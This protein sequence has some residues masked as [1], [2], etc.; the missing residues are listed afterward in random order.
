MAGEI[1][2]RIYHTRLLPTGLLLVGVGIGVS[3]V[4]ESFKSI[5]VKG[6][7]YYKKL[8]VEPSR[9]KLVAAWRTANNSMLLRRFVPNLQSRLSLDSEVKSSIK[10][11]KTRTKAPVEHERKDVSRRSKHSI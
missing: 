2:E 7:A 9:L 11:G 6:V 5:H 10:E 1:P 3:L 4:P 8:A